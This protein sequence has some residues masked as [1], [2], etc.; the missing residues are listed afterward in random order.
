VEPCASII[1][2]CL[3]TLGP[4]LQHWRAPQSIATAT[5]PIVSTSGAGTKSV[6]VSKNN[7]SLA[8]NGW[9][10]LGEGGINEAGVVSRDTDLELG[11]LDQGTRQSHRAIYVERTFSVDGS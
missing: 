5:H 9:L 3:P 7:S 11:R 6:Q 1:A 4:F 8:E 2:A 10:E